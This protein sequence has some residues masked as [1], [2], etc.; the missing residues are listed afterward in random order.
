M[1]AAPPPSDASATA[2][3]TPLPVPKAG[4]WPD[5]PSVGVIGAGRWGKNLIRNF[6]QLHALHSVCDLSED[7]RATL[8]DQYP[9]I[10]TTPDANHIINNPAI[11][12]VVIATPSQTHYGLACAAIAAG[13]HVY[14]EKPLATTVQ[15]V[16]DLI[17]V[18]DMMD[19]RLMVGHLLIYHPAVIRLKQL[20]A[21][22]ALGEIYWLESTRLNTNRFRP[23]NHVLWD[24][25][26]HDLSMMSVV[27][28][29]EPTELLGVEGTTTGADKKIDRA[30]MH[31]RFGD[32]IQGEV[33]NSWV[34]PLK[35]VQLMVY[36][37]EKIAVLDDTQPL[38]KKLI[39]Y[40]NP[41][42]TPPP[43]ALPEPQP[44]SDVLSIEPL[45]MECQHFLNAIQSGTAPTTDARHARQIVAMLEAASMHL[46][47]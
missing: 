28:G 42:A 38:D 37:T 47:S 46:G 13:K 32:S 24:L 14:V 40:P 2:A 12:A 15:E 9:D 8:T 23:D 27:I 45:A 22:G 3:V 11:H 33:V 34:H 18:A 39:L 44:I 5:V 4:R 7:N 6:Y 1:T 35:Q 43:E 21:E 25:A 17:A 30:R 19:V 10:E 20:I 31:V 26:P 41:T 16:D 29:E 36:G